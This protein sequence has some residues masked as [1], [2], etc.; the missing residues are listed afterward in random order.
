M[1][2]KGK[3]I[4]GPPPEMIVFNR[5]DEDLVFKAKAVLDYKEFN[6]L[7]PEP[8]PPVNF[9]AGDDKGVEDEEDPDYKI[10]IS[11]HGRLRYLW[12]MIE[13]L[14]ATEDLEWEKLNPKDPSTWELLTEEF[15]NSGLTQ[16]EL[17]HLQMIVQKANVMN[18]EH[19]EEAKKRF[20]AKQQV[21]LQK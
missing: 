13:S 19:L 18:E 8:K 12:M 20:L 1:K 6:K 9:K 21:H 16:F 14:S 7:C 11:K 10:A 3:K 5:G 15:E 2:L 4:E 17:V